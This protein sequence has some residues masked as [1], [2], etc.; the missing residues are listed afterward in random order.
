MSAKG[1]GGWG[2]KI[3][4]F[5]DIQYCIYSNIVGGSEKV[6]KYADIL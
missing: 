5:A 4:I 6:E 3:G 2:Q 1:L